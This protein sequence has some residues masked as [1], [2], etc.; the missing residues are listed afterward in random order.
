MAERRRVLLRGPGSGSKEAVEEWVVRCCGWHP[1]SV[2]LTEGGHIVDC[3]TREQM[4]FLLGLNG[5]TLATGVSLVVLKAPTKL[6]VSDIF[7]VGEK[8][9]TLSENVAS[10]RGQ[11][12]SEPASTAAVKAVQPKKQKEAVLPPP[13]PPPHEEEPAET[14]VVEAASEKSENPGKGSGKG[15]APDTQQG[16]GGGNKG[17]GWG[18]NNNTQG[19]RGKGGGSKGGGKG[20][21]KGKGDGDKG[22]WDGGKGWG[23]NDWE[24]GW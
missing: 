3:N 19:G 15:S 7:A 17:R 24:G 20:K 21:G 13:P 11:L 8:E 10:L 14:M 16:R 6:T 23:W 2:T 18:K 22:R 9:L 5:Q 12:S 1:R 4:D